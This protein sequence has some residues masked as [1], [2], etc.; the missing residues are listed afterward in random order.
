MSTIK[1]FLEK[2]FSNG[3][4]RDIGTKEVC[5]KIKKYIL[6]NLMS[7]INIDD[8]IE[9]TW[10][11][12]YNPEDLAAEN[13]T[14]KISVTETEN[15]KHKVFVNIWFPGAFYDNGDINNNE[16]DYNDVCEMHEALSDMFDELNDVRPLFIPL[17][18][19]SNENI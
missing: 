6:E 14:I 13:T 12:D 9:F 7:V 11:A 17:W 10:N 8:V 2:G 4:Y 1:Q 19:A 18:E 3:R 15:K 5:A 16:D